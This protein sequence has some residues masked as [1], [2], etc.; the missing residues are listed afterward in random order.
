MPDRRV[1]VIVPD[2]QA[3][4]SDVRIGVCPDAFHLFGDA[5][6]HALS[7]EIVYASFLGTEMQYTLHT[8]LGELFVRSNEVF[9]NHPLGSRVGIGFADHGIAIVGTA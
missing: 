2:R 5:A 9:N 7:G 6:S 3:R 8:P 1:T 4:L